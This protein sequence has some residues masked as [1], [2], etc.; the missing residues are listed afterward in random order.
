M[1]YF[2]Q[3]AYYHGMYPRE[4]MGF[5]DCYYTNAVFHAH[6]FSPITNTTVFNAPHIPTA[7]V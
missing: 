3:V 4:A 1:L 7:F 5:S 2:H 6:F